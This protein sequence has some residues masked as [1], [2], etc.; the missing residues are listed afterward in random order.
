MTERS[1]A[2]VLATE[3]VDAVEETVD[4]ASFESDRLL[5]SRF[6]ERRDSAAFAELVRRHERLVMGTSYR[7]LRN[8]QAAE[9]AFQETFLALARRASTI[10]VLDSLTGWL[11]RVA[12]NAALRVHRDALRRQNRE[13][14]I[15]VRPVAEAEEFREDEE[16]KRALD[17]ALDELP[18]KYRSAIILCHL[19]GLTNEDAALRMGC[20]KG[21]ISTLLSRGLDLLKRH[22]D[23]RNVTIPGGL[24]AALVGLKAEAAA[25]A[26][27]VAAVVKT[28]AGIKAA[29]LW[30][31][32]GKLAGTA[33]LVAVAALGTGILTAGI[34]D[35]PAPAR[36]ALRDV[37]LTAVPASPVLPD[38][39]RLRAERP[40]A[41]PQ[42]AP[43]PEKPEKS[44][45]ERP[46]KAEPAQAAS[47]LEIP[48]LP[49]QASEQAQAALQRAL[50]RSPG[51]K[52]P[53][54]KAPQPP[55]AQ[56]KALGHEKSAPPGLDRAMEASRQ[57]SQKAQ[58]ALQKNRGRSGK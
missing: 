36:E 21:S 29:S 51:R 20:P 56:G 34:P 41:P 39:A 47:P 4:A 6:A 2:E 37:P 55:R 45:P 54:V 35:L 8:V 22:L 18:V 52:E 15:A 7:I 33:A 14:K 10:R 42:A 48:D 31:V 43:A 46:E 57:A 44:K 5:L 19:E 25:P 1:E 11:H 3:A 27:L 17:Q 13:A 26:A 49:E 12:A 30:L 24:L 38:P 58:E 32:A 50:D 9:D 28:A 53:G 23:R 16:L 40:A